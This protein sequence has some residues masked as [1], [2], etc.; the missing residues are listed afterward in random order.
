LSK[1]PTTET[2]LRA[3]G[4]SS[5]S[6]EALAPEMRS[7]IAG[8]ARLGARELCGG[9][10]LPGVTG[11]AVNLLGD[12]SQLNATL[13]GP[14]LGPA[15]DSGL[16]E[17]L[18]VVPLSAAV[19]AHVVASADGYVDLSDPEKRPEDIM[20]RLGGAAGGM[21]HAYLGVAVEVE[22]VRV[23][24]LCMYGTA[25]VGPEAR[26]AR[27]VAMRRHGAILSGQLAEVRRLREENARIQSQLRGIGSASGGEAAIH[28]S[29]EDAAAWRETVAILGDV[30]RAVAAAG[31]GREAAGVVACVIEVRTTGS[32]GAAIVATSEAAIDRHGMRPCRLRQVGD[33]DLVGYWH[34]ALTAT[35]LA[36][37]DA[38]AGPRTHHDDALVAAVAPARLGTPPGA[39]ASLTAAALPG[40]PDHGETLRGLVVL[41]AHA[42]SG[43]AER[44]ARGAL[45]AQF[46][47][48]VA[49]AHHAALAVYL[50]P[51][52]EPPR[53]PAGE[54][55]VDPEV[56]AS[57]RQAF[58]TMKLRGL[59]ALAEE[60]GVPGA[61]DAGSTEDLLH[62]LAA[63]ASV[64]ARARRAHLRTLSVR[65]LLAIGAAGGMEKVEAAESKHDMIAGILEAEGIFASHSPVAALDPLPV[66]PRKARALTAEQATLAFDPNATWLRA[67]TAREHEALPYGQPG[68][69]D[70]RGFPRPPVPADESAR[71]AAIESLGVA[72]MRDWSGEELATF[73]GIAAAV[74]AVAG[75]PNAMLTII[76]RAEHIVIGMTPRALVAPLVLG[77]AA[78]SPR[79]TSYCQY[80]VAKGAALAVADTHLPEAGPIG[81]VASRDAELKAGF[82]AL[83][84]AYLGVPMVTAEGVVL[85]NVCAI[86]SK[87]RPDFLSRPGLVEQ[88][89]ALAAAAV[90]LFELRRLRSENAEL[91][92]RRA[93]NVAAVEPLGRATAGTVP[94]TDRV[95]LLMTDIEGSTALH[96]RDASLM[97]QALD[98]HDAAMR[99]AIADNGGIEITT[100]GDAF[101]VAFHTAADAIRCAFDAQLRLLAAPWPAGLDLMAPARTDESRKFRGCRVRMTVH[102]A[103]AGGGLL[104][105]RCFEVSRHGMTRRPQ[106]RGRVVDVCRFFSDMPS[107]GQILVTEQ[108]FDEVS[109]ALTAALGDPQVIDLGRYE[110][111]SLGDVGH[112]YQ[113]L[114]RALSTRT[115]DPPVRVPSGGRLTAPGY[116][117]APR[118]SPLVI[119]F[120]LPVGLTELRL[121]SDA[122]H[123]RG[124]EVF[125][126]TTREA[127]RAH[128]G[129]EMKENDG[130]FMCAFAHTDAGEAMA[131]GAELHARLAAA[132]GK[133][134]R[135]RVGAHGGDV[136]IEPHPSTGR[137]DAF[138]PACNRAA[139]MAKA[140]NPGQTI[141][142]AATAASAVG[143][144][145]PLFDLGEHGFRGLEGTIRVVQAG[146]G[147]F[148]PIQSLRD[149]SELLDFDFDPANHLARARAALGLL[150]ALGLDSV[151][152]PG[153]HLVE[154]QTLDVAVTT[155]LAAREARRAAT[156]VVPRVPLPDLIAKPP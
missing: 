123:A 90:N 145:L 46:A 137:M 30:E 5:E 32:P 59:L 147:F 154:R 25:P 80:G 136:T 53:T 102:F 100:E 62:L 99:R 98:V 39:F 81:L 138:G 97:K 103:E 140:A 44:A 109:L 7:A 72:G 6:F 51:A 54:G 79:A 141:I 15:R 77:D 119:V 63:H 115:F 155:A 124:L 139:R 47:V 156:L 129:Y 8:F 41:C 52:S 83:P 70:L 40:A 28:R 9:Q 31:D 11:V 128:G 2:Q 37:G 131:F 67:A 73:D 150:D 10:L 112:A 152:G 117:H 1:P 133:V 134:L 68:G 142:D 14:L 149:G 33:D 48:M 91:H 94:P 4:L 108:A 114:P 118:V 86:D 56:L 107:G 144:T 57:V 24:T 55:T 121:R 92:A 71:I 104:G 96:E 16:L 130:A 27:E 148:P 87:P 43:E 34:A 42:A 75:T 84:R 22:G 143:L 19:C 78:A 74:A 116:I 36:A 89:G 146:E 17:R 127:L 60:R 69:W 85:G 111:A 29:E 105:A 12:R 23:G 82:N 65:E 153:G 58:G 21:L 120:A 151:P 125:A 93:L 110:D 101:I 49:E 38:A 26:G 122:A 18:R 66:P 20:D 113:L 135:C 88:M 106:Y 76:H 13:A 3:L 126:G 64:L 50:T 132:T 95:A 35:R 45:V 61:E